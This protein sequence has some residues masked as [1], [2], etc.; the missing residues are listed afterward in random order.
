MAQVATIANR[1]REEG[2]KEGWTG[3]NSPQE[4]K[5]CF[6]FSSILHM[7]WLFMHDTFFGVAKNG[8]VT[9]RDMICLGLKLTKGF[10][11]GPSVWFITTI[12]VCGRESLKFT[13]TIHDK[14]RS[15]DSQSHNMGGE[16]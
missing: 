12:R 3:P 9:G 15:M 10:N 16:E 7:N 2:R 13:M 8:S 11:S 6:S 4:C 5:R 1:M 14:K